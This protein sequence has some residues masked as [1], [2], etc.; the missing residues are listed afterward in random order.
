MTDKLS[1]SIIIEGKMRGVENSVTKYYG[2]FINSI[3]ERR[4]GQFY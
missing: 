4:F 2:S 3:D 1:Q